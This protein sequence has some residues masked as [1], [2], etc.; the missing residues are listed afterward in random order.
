MPSGATR[1]LPG[2]SVSLPKR[3]P[4][5]RG[6]GAR[7]PGRGPPLLRRDIAGVVT[8][9]VWSSI[10]D[11]GTAELSTNRHGARHRLPP[12]ARVRRSRSSS[13]SRLRS[14]LGRGSWSRTALRSS[15]CVTSTLCSSTRQG[16]SPSASARHRHRRSRR[17]HHRGAPRYRGGRR[18]R[19][20]P[21][22]RAIV[23][24][25]HEQGSLPRADGFLPIAGR[26]VEATVASTS[27]AVG[28]PALLRERNVA[29]PGV[30]GRAAEAWADRGATVLLRPARPGSHRRACSRGRDPSRARALRSTDCTSSASE[31]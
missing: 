11:S 18:D 12:R 21:L 6:P 22:A 25:A 7:R 14:R 13:R 23:A 19:E 28:G 29:V 4:L 26:G 17:S 5:D 24:A 16:R 20:H 30:L 9:V 8:F 1:R 15:A 2:S 27:V 31:S 10:G 3:R